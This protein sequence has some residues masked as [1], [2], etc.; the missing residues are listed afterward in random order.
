MGNKRRDERKNEDTR[1]NCDRS[2]SKHRWEQYI[3]VDR[4]GTN[5]TNVFEERENA[6]EIN[7]AKQRRTDSDNSVFH[8]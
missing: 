7:E 3:L 6:S 8:F 2:Q 4:N 5:C 1:P